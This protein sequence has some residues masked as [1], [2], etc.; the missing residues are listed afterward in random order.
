[1]AEIMRSAAALKY[2]K[3]G[4]GLSVDAN[5]RDLIL[6]GPRLF[7]AKSTFRHLVSNLNQAAVSLIQS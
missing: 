3:K 6:R 5:L 7:F 4:S 1:M 2:S